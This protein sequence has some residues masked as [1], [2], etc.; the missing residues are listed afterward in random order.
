MKILVDQL[1]NFIT[2]K[3]ATRWR[4]RLPI[5]DNRCEKITIDFIDDTGNLEEKCENRCYTLDTHFM[6]NIIAGF[7]KRYHFGIGL[8]KKK[9][10]I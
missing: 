6:S 3:D 2:K 7:F 9:L 5:N 10:L 8:T 4:L 1:Q